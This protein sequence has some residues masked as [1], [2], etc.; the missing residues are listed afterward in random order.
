MDA[1]IFWRCGVEGCFGP[2]VLGLGFGGG[3][4]W[5]LCLGPLGF[6]GFG[7]RVWGVGFGVARIK[8]AERVGRAKAWSSKSHLQRKELTGLQLR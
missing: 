8:G 3:G 5:G 6:R 1:D 2:K 4:V 7:F